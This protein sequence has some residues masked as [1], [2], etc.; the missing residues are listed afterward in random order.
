MILLG[1]IHGDWNYLQKIV[2]SNS[3]KSI[4]CLGDFGYWPNT[5]IWPPNITST[6]PIYFIDG[7][8]ENFW[9][10]KDNDLLLWEEPKKV[11]GNIYYLSR[12]LTFKL[13]DKNILCCGGG[14]S[15]D[16]LYRTIGQN[17]FPEESISYTDVQK[18]IEKIK[19]EEIDLV[20]THAAPSCFK[21]ETK[22][23]LFPINKSPSENNL[24]Y[25]VEAIVKYQEK[26]PLWVFAHYHQS[27]TGEYSLNNQI[28]KWNALRIGEVYEIYGF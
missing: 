13:E 14:E 21:I 22:I 3:N 7:N 20:I 9:A 23:N 28:I 11:R 19:D 17:W 25:L 8:H 27:A 6:T 15:I 5:E 10:M 4:I 1:D 18:C 12:G 2:N 26:M 16:R 24:N